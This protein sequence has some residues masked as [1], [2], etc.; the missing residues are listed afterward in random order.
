MR[1]T[2]GRDRGQYGVKRY[3]PTGSRGTFS[4]YLGK[5]VK[6][7]CRLGDCSITYHISFTQWT[8]MKRGRKHASALIIPMFSASLGYPDPSK[9]VGAGNILHPTC[10]GDRSNHR[11]LLYSCKAIPT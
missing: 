5:G 1:C 2:H 10:M 6:A 8:E 7:L 9:I 4:I 11:P 3:F